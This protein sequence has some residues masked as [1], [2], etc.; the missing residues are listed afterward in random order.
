[1][2]YLPKIFFFFAMANPVYYDRISRDAC[3]L[4][5]RPLA[6]IPLRIKAV[7]SVILSA[8]YH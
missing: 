8:G 3:T 4:L 2:I 5:T 1:M 7:F 6:L